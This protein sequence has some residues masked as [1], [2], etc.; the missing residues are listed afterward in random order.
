[1][2]YFPTEPCFINIIETP[3]T[4][5][6]SGRTETGSKFALFP[7]GLIPRSYMKK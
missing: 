6:L 5:Q 1:M 2:E 4:E 3:V 7:T